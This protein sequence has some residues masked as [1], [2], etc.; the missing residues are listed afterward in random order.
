MCRFRPPPPALLHCCQGNRSGRFC[1]GSGSAAARILPGI[2]VSKRTELR[3]VFIGFNGKEKLEDGRP[4]PF[5]DARVRQ[6]VEASIDRDLINKKIMRGLARPS[7]SLIAPEIAGYAEALDVYQ[8]ADPKRAQKLLEEANQ[9]GLAFTYLC[10]NDESINEEDI[11]SGIANMLKRAGFEPTIDMGPRA[12]QQPKRTNGKA[13]MF[14]L[15]WANEPTLDAYSLLSQV[16]STRSG[17]TGV[18]NYGG[19]SYPELDDLVKR[20]PKSLTLQSG[21]HWKN[22]HSRLPRI[23]QS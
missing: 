14:N 16:L 5:L 15:S 23:R 18:S 9:K 10:M 7:G 6:A 3:T 2:K 20:Q 11:C 8:P 22:R 4:N 21:W 1:A 17:S 19:W 13:D 12:V